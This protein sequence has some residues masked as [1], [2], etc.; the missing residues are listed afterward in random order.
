MQY[1]VAGCRRCLSSGRPL[2]PVRTG[3]AVDKARR[4]NNVACTEAETH[5][6]Y[7]VVNACD[8]IDRALRDRSSQQQWAFEGDEAPHNA[9]VDT[10]RWRC[11]A[12][13]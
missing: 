2:G 11:V 12:A 4:P 1:L 7:A 6:L 8:A 3:N 10:Q 5:P 9:K 13:A